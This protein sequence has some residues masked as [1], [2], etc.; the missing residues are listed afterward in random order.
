MWATGVGCGL[1]T[2]SDKIIRSDQSV[3]TRAGSITNM[4]RPGRTEPANNPTIGCM[5]GLSEAP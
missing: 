5:N 1:E 3:S 4:P 2:P